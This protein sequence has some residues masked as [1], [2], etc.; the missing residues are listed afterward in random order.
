MRI[1]G[2]EH[3]TAG[4]GRRR[5][6]A[7]L[8]FGVCLCCWL[9]GCAS[10]RGVPD[11]LSDTEYRAFSDTDLSA[12]LHVA[13]QLAQSWRGDR[14]DAYDWVFWSNISLIPLAA[15]GAGAAL[16]HGSHDLITGIGLTAGTLIGTNNMIG[17][18]AIGA[19]YQGGIVGLSCI[20]SRLSPYV[21]T[22][23]A[24]A[25][26]DLGKAADDLDQLI[27]TG[28]Q[29]LGQSTG[30]SLT[31]AAAQAERLADPSIVSTLANNESVLT[32]AIANAKIAV[33]SA[34]TETQLDATVATYARDRII[35]VDNIVAMKIKPNTVNFAALSSSLATPAAA[36]Q[37]PAIA[38]ATQQPKP[39]VHKLGGATP[40]ADMAK[41][42]KRAADDL[43][44][45][46]QNLSAST[47][48]FG[49]STQESNVALC[50]KNL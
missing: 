27:V 8:V 33:A 38:G 18:A 3:R 10:L 16:Y 32:Q 1:P 39:P 13:Q 43:I 5:I 23:K 49:L 12:N 44:T 47:S 45:A 6:T 26:R 31:S 46:T 25:A 17:A 9:A 48:A 14:N 2:I 42:T 20:Y 41:A 50:I 28:N 29:A 11:D 30:L 22:D 35:D 34:R 37:P 4:Y 40:I 15:G 24:K 21:G 7:R 36:Q 19:D